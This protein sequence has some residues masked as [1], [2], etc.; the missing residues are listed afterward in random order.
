MS[1]L[2]PGTVSIP[3]SVL[4]ER[5]RGVTQ[6]QEHVWRPTGVQVD[7]LDLPPWTQ[8]HD[9]GTRALFHAGVADVSLFPTDT[10][11]YKHNL[12]AEAPRL[13][14]ILRTSDAAPGLALHAVTADAGEAHL[15]TDSGNDLVEA[16]PLPAELHA[17]I[18]D[19]IAEHHVERAFHKRRRDRQDTESLAHRP[20]DDDDE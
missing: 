15:Y 10:L 7:T 19:F 16:L 6:W 18:A 13:W 2:I 12:D 4:V 1:L 20:R 11:N 14:V 8:L 5:R 3:V 9:D 17:R